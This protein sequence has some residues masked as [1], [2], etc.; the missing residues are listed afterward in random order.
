MEDNYDVIVIGAGVAGGLIANEVARQK[1][2]VLILE[3]GV[4]DD[5]RVGLVGNYLKSTTRSLGSPYFPPG[6][7]NKAPSPDGILN[8]Y[9]DQP[10]NPNS[11]SFFKSNYERRVG[12]STWHWLGN[13]PRLLPNDFRSQTLYGFGRDWPITYDDL[14]PWYCKA[15]HELGVSGDHEEL[16]GLFGAH[17]S[18]P[19]PMLK[20][21]PS[22]SDLKITEALTGYKNLWSEYNHEDLV[23]MSTP[24]ARNSRPYDGRPVCTGNSSCVPIC[25][26]GAK[27]D[28]SV[29]IKKAEDNGAKLHEKAIVTRIVADTSGKITGVVYKTWDDKEVTVTAKIYVLAANAIESPKLLLMSGIANGSD[30]VGRNLMDHPQ[31]EGL[32]IASEPLFPFRGPPT[33]SGIDKFRDGAFRKDMCAFRMSMGNDGGGR[34]QSPSNVLN[35]MVQDSFGQVLRN[36]LREK[37]TRQFRISFLSEM[38]PLPENRVTVSPIQDFGVPRPKIDFRVDDYTLNGF[39]KIA[40]VM[41]S[42]LLALGSKL[43]DI[44]LPT[45][46]TP[47][48]AAGHIMGTCRMGNDPKDSVVDRDCRSHENKNLFIAGSSVFPTGGTANPTLTLAALSL[49]IADTILKD[50]TQAVNVTQLQS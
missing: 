11:N 14:E 36:K 2:S 10:A 40:E 39:D 45:S 20:I 7:V 25:P 17:R 48:M 15:E 43:E 19:F 34:S 5:N 21:W 8:E 29:H 31:G 28:A 18:K 13:C 33:T 12:G 26:V 27:Y 41:K 24:Q 42:I 6:M 35:A 32:C 1:K 44:K 16:D 4:K 9:Y 37:V 38:K 22:Y 23:L 47:F 3:A 49:R 46:S 30:Q 50:L